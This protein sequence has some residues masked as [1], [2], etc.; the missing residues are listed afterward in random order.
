LQTEDHNQAL[1][2]NRILET[3]LHFREYDGVP[4]VHKMHGFAA[5]FPP[6]LPCYFIKALTKPEDIV[7]D[8]M[9]GSGTV[10]VEALIQGRRS[11]GIDI[12]PLAALQC[13]VKTRILDSRRM[14]EKAKSI[15]ARTAVLRMEKSNT[16]T[17][18]D[19]KSLDNYSVEAREFFRYWFSPITV[20]EL[21]LLVSE[22]NEIE[23]PDIRDALRLSLSSTIISKNA[24]VSLAIDITHTRPHKIEGKRVP[25]AIASFEKAARR[26]A[27]ALEELENKAGKC[28]LKPN[29]LLGD[30]KALPIN[31]ES[32]KL[33]VTS[34]PYATGLDYMRSHKFSLI[35]FGHSPTTLSALRSKYIGSESSKENLPVETQL[36][37]IDSSL[38]Q[39]ALHNAHKARSIARYFNEMKAVMK[40]IYRVLEYAGHA[41]VVVGPSMSRGNRIMTQDGLGEIADD[42]GFVCLGTKKRE[43][44]RDRRQLPIS[45]ASSGKGI[46]ARMHEEYI[47]LLQKA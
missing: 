39:I 23:E 21:S 37:S 12:D 46:E 41:V 29:V 25:S 34:P 16:M 44:E 36:Q 26:T 6:Q 3:P 7:L 4:S 35:W 22:I 27:H 18:N 20:T 47:L 30:A 15:A 13:K 24:G 8:P 31:N 9:A 42:Q 1:E 14:L 11:I 2:S 28:Y 19:E 43:I 40:E 45:S 17:A 33:V 32:V 38:R 10:L 5:K